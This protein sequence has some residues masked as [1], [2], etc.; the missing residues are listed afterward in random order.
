M[1][2]KLIFNLFQ[3]ERL[4]QEKLKVYRI[5]KE[6]E[7]EE[8]ER[9]RSEEQYKEDLIRSE[10]ERLLRENVPN[11]TRFIPKGVLLKPEHLRYIGE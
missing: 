8:I 6:K 5:E 10:M 3:I 9:R 4:W 1:T 11:L 7:L 2:T